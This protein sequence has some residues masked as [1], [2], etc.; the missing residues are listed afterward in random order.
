MDIVQIIALVVAWALTVFLSLA[1]FKAGKFKFTAPI[2]TLVAAG[3]AWTAE[4]PKGLVRTIGFVEILGVVG[5]ILAPLA[6]QFVGLSWAQPWGVAAAFGLVLTMV[7]A[8]IM[9]I[10]RGEFKY[11][12]KINLQLFFAALVLTVLLAQYGAPLFA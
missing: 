2:E 11:T 1:Y 10:A 7:V 9:H 5:I 6:S 12:Y 8:I 3:L 4:I